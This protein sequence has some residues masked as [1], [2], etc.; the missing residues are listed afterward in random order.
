MTNEP[1]SRDKNERETV[2]L[3]IVTVVGGTKIAKTY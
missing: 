1:T 3:E 2:P